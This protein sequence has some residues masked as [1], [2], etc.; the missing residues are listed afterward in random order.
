MKI[1]KQFLV[2]LQPLIPIL[3]ALKKAGALSYLVGGTVRDLLLEHDIKDIDIE[4]HHLTLDQLEELLRTFGPVKLV[5]KK[6]GVLRLYYHDVDWSLPRRDSAGR[7]PMVII[8]PSLTI[9]QACRRRDVTMNAMAIN[10]NSLVDTFQDMYSRIVE[11]HETLALSHVLDIVD[12]YGGRAALHDKALRAVDVTL[13]VE[14]PLRF[15][16]V[17]QFIG[18][19]EM[20]PD[21]ELHD[22]CASMDLRD[23]LTHEPLARERI[24]EEIKKLLLKSKRPSLGFRWLQQLGRLKELFP[25][26]H[27]LVGVAQRPDYHPEGDVFEHTMQALDAAAVCDLYQDSQIGMTAEQE[28]FLI[29]LAVL[30]HDLGK[31]TTT[32][33]QL[34]CRGHEEEGVKIARSFLKTIS[35]D[36]FLLKGISKLIE[37]HIAP[38][39]FVREK[40]GSKAYKRL[41]LKLAP[42]VNLRQLALVALADHRGRNAKNSE[43]LHQG[44]EELDSFW[45]R[46][47]TLDVL[48]KAEQPILLGRHLSDVI[49]PGPKMGELLKEAYRIQIEEDIKDEY[50]LKRRVVELLGK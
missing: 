45:E 49:Q 16:R 30:C 38:F 41:A 17:M 29:M 32:D 22:L 24:F 2:M 21:P 44:F 33:D 40:A 8:D 39:S 47:Q 23:P 6:F 36:A 9:E 1:V 28:K 27:A 37:H 7:K 10:L 26:L 5:G 25:E 3:I 13:F 12:P 50:E 48:D 14:D 35:D 31:P 42:E 19:F 20:M 46:A 11:N 43:P 18:R 4:V 15:F 34:R